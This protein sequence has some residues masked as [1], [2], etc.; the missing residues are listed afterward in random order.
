MC[1]SIVDKCLEMSRVP[2]T[3]NCTVCPSVNLVEGYI[4]HLSDMVEKIS[5]EVSTT[6]LKVRYPQFLN[7][8]GGTIIFEIMRVTCAVA[9]E[10]FILR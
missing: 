1:D 8:R 6:K 4:K 7:G 3:Y 10:F 5:K 2:A 9:S